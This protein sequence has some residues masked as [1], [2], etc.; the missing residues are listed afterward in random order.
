M[1]KG[2][3][4][5]IFAWIFIILGLIVTYG[6]HIGIIAMG[7][8]QTLVL[9]HAISNLVASIF[10]TFGIILLAIACRR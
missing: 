7:L 8:Q 5:K 10:I 4:M 3:G 9:S 6:T 2:R 1:A